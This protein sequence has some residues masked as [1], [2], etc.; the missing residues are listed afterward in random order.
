MTNEVSKLTYLERLANPME[1]I[2]KTSHPDELFEAVSNA[3]GIIAKV[4]DIVKE[5]EGEFENQMLSIIDDRG[6]CQLGNDKYVRGVK[7]SAKQ[8]QAMII[9]TDLLK[10][11]KG[12]KDNVT[13]IANCIASAG[14]KKG[15]V[16]KIL[17]DKC[18]HFWSVETDALKKSVL[19][20]YNVAFLTEKK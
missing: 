11:T 14:F 20:K 6:P 2:S 7:K 9:L 10:A 3:R 17:G 8:A 1:A 13:S 5:L 12:S 18:P 15:E 19:K 16:E 4:K